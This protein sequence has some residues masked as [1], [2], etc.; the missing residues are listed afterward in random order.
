LNFS[1][2]V[3]VS[4]IKAANPWHKAL[5]VFLL[6]L[7]VSLAVRAS[8]EYRWSD[9]GFGDA[10]TM[11]SLRQWN[12]GGW[13]HNYLLFKPQGYAKAIDLLDEPTLRHHAHGTCPGSSPNVGPRLWYTHYPAGYLI[14]YALLFRID[15]TGLFAARLLSIIFS[16]AAIG[17][18]YL[19]FSKLTSPVVSF[20]SVL[21][22]ALSP[23]F[24]GYAD[25]LANQPLDDLLRF[26][27][28]LAV[29]L[30]TRAASERLRN[31][32]LIAAWVIE[33]CLSLASFDS[34]FFLYV[35]LVSWDLI[36]GKGFRWKRYLVFACAPVS[37]HGL[38]FLQNAWYLGF[39]DAALDIKDAFLL[40]NGAD[41][42][43]NA[44]YGKLGIIYLAATT[45]FENIFK[46]AWLL[47]PVALVYAV[48]TRSLRRQDSA[49]PSFKLLAALFLCGL[50]FVLVLPN[51]ARMPYEARQMLPFIALLMGA[52]TVSF[53]DVFRKA[54]HPEHTDGDAASAPPVWIAAPYLLFTMILLLVVWYR[55]AFLER[56]PV[57]ELGSRK[58]EMVFAQELQK[59]PTRY[60]PVY[61]DL[62]AFSTFWDPN[63]VPGYPQILPLT[64]YY[65]GS[66]PILC[67][68]EPKSVAQDIVL[69]V[70]NAPQPFS[71]V[72]L[73]KDNKDIERILDALDEIGSLKVRPQNYPQN[74]GRFAADLTDL[75]VRR[76][77]EIDPNSRKP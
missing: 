57:Y 14:P 60:E 74:M 52:L 46:P 59:L 40:K 76:E 13:L 35:W 7:F 42:N 34:V 29:V 68:R 54:V 30:S 58:E 27:F 19:L 39:Q 12:E 51:G 45:V 50:A 3:V 33:F 55:F 8:D 64:E 72:I 44:G 70:Q 77:H 65:A 66:R 11:L 1:T 25:S 26:G 69:M 9:W 63:Y 17:L 4:R 48:F 43:Y 21:F 71:P 15:I 6:V 5:V 31:R 36:E 38:Q 56:Y 22:Y 28:M 24:L 49:F 53:P 62:G 23:A 2:E 18:M 32:W 61:F 10:Q 67:F 47:I 41:V 73:A 75:I 20:V 37:A 16:V